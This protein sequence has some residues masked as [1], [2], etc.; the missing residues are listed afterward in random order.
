MDNQAN[1][2][3]D[4][5]IIGVGVG[6]NYGSVL[7]YYS[8]YQTV[9]SFGNKVLMVSKIGA[10]A[11]DPEIQNTHAIKFARKHYNLS[12]IYSQ[13]TV[14]ELNRIANTFVIGSDQVW[15]YGIS[16]H[17]GKAFYLD[18]TEDSKRRI[19]YAASFGHSKDFSPPDEVPVISELMRRFHAI[20]VREDSGVK[21]ARDIYQ[22]PAKQ[23]AEPIFLLDTQRYLDLAAQST[24]DVSGPYLL[25]YILD[26]TPEKKAAIEHV[27]KEK[28]LKIRIILDAWP[29]LFE[30]NKQSMGIEG[31]VE[32]GIDTYDFLKLYANSSYVLTDSF[33]GTAFALK[34]GKPFASIG[35]KRRG[36]A[37]F[38]SLFGIVGHKERFT[39]D[40]NDILT[41][42]ADFLAP[43]DYTSIHAALD[44][45]VKESKLWLKSALKTPI[46][47]TIAAVEKKKLSPSLGARL[48]NG[49]LERAL[50]KSAE[51]IKFQM[52]KQKFSLRAPQFTANSDA[53]TVTHT[54]Q[55][56]QLKAVSP[57]RGNLVWTDLPEPL[58]E[59][60]AYEL[61]IDWTVRTA[62]DLVNVHIRNP[63]TGK[64]RVIGAVA[65][66]KKTNVPRTDKLSFVVP[67]S[68]FSQIMFG[69]VHF[70]GVNAGA[71]ITGI[72]LRS[73]PKEAVV[74]NAAPAAPSKRKKDAATVVR[75]L[76][77][78]DINRFINFYAQHRIS[79]N[80]ENARSL[81][82]FYSH[83]FEKGLSRSESFRPGFGKDYML[84]LAEEMNK[85]IKAGRDPKDSFFQIAASV[86]HN[87]F[88]RH[89]EIGFDVSHFWKLFHTPVQEAIQKA[90]K[91]TGGVQAAHLT[92][93]A[94]VDR[95]QNRSFVD[96]V[97]S[98]RSVREFTSDPVRNEDIE[99]AIRIAQQAPSV[100]NRQ[101][102]R[103]HQFTNPDAIKAAL[104]LQGGF[105]GY[106]TPPKLLLITS[107]LSAF[108][109]AVERNQAFIDGGLFMMLLLLGLEQMGL[110]GCSLNTAMN[111]EREK[112]IRNIL[113]IP[114]NEVFISFVAVG[115][116]DPAV[117]TPRSKRIPV[118]EVLAS[119]EKA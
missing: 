88:E 103:V 1:E 79:R 62:S 4:V 38:H 106:K 12:K 24:R 75:E 42:S 101:P 108:V 96:V 54:G 82:M 34:F 64:F 44:A 74:P 48:R 16:Q 92:R 71:D 113:N 93:E 50:R 61:T 80:V 65:P 3:Y 97:F 20:S 119:H 110:G 116:Y 59:D 109:G 58:K 32:E 45:H 77:E 95:F 9:Q 17:F 69:A 55:A 7:T 118:Q 37:R 112:A 10:S 39:L 23:V 25:A 86:M 52:S 83:G 72:S 53:W 26:P 29:H 13:T 117:L 33:H 91:G 36:V 105:R 51:L 114:E 22:V 49:K 100:C 6:A 56:T 43:L 70:I 35:N 102:V 85:W 19:S 14:H 94:E 5:A 47:N 15:N 28:N 73:I 115:H 60:S 11:D 76:G 63:Q 111:A 66:K 8:L 67:T 40:A 46:R 41:R 18:F 2:K 99:R 107:D 27:A 84:P 21:I 78:H 90:D 68:G 57:V 89:R 104:E 30:K 98:R 31:A 87:Y 81:L